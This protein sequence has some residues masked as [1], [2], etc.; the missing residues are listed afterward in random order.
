MRSPAACSLFNGKDLS[1]WKTL[2]GQSAHWKVVSSRLAFQC[3]EEFLGGL[4]RVAE[5]FLLL[6][7]VGANRSRCHV[8]ESR[9]EVIGMRCLD[10]V[11]KRKRRASRTVARRGGRRH[12]RSPAPPSE[13]GLLKSSPGALG[14]DTTD[15]HGIATVSP[16]SGVKRAAMRVDSVCEVE[17]ADGAA[18]GE[19]E[20][21]AVGVDGAPVV[22]V[23]DAGGRRGSGVSAMR[24][25]PLEPPTK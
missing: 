15:I 18:V 13:G 20:V 21:D 14:S 24:A 23:V 9:Q 25:V 17:Q 16:P 1:G 5:T 11:P 12:P 2:P 3:R 7:T 10:I 6:P 8:Q 4:G 22:L 19:Q